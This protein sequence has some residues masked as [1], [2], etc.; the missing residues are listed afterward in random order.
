MR[1]S[2]CQMPIDHC[3]QPWSL[4]GT[5]AIGTADDDLVLI[6]VF[7]VDLHA[8]FVASIELQGRVLAHAGQFRTT[9]GWTRNSPLDAFGDNAVEI[10]FMKERISSIRAATS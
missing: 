9:V 5:D 7:W 1:L 3:Q 4:G 6:K 10:A 2:A 8:E